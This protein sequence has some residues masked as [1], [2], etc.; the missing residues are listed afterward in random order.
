VSESGD[1]SIFAHRLAQIMFN[2]FYMSYLLLVGKAINII[3]INVFVQ[4]YFR[5]TIIW[6]NFDENQIH[7][8]YET[9][10]IV[11]Q[12]SDSEYSSYCLLAAIPESWLPCDD[13]VKQLILRV[14]K[15]YVYDKKFKW[16]NCAIYKVWNGISAKYQT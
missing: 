2:Y 15:V 12:Q 16:V 11:W 4:L 13:I 10:T 14:G 6:I 8:V 5:Q 3:V 1:D 7:H 9:D